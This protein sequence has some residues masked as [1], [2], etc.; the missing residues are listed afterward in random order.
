ME[1]KERMLACH[2][3]QRAWLRHING[4]DS[5]IENMKDM[6]RTDGNRIGR[7]WGECFIQHLQAPLPTDNIL[8]KELGDLVVG[9][10]PLCLPETPS[11]MEKADS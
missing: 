8:K 7:E 2:D 6:S 9:I 3:S 4:W 5:Y 1:T 10:E 11:R